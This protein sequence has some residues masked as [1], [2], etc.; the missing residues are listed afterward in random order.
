M[1]D[2]KNKNHVLVDEKTDKE[3]WSYG[4]KWNQINSPKNENCYY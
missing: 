2:E 3:G 1:T 4:N